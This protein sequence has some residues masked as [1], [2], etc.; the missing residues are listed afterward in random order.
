MYKWNAKETHKSS[1]EQQKCAQELIS[2]LAL[3]GNERE[4]VPQLI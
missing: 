4:A 1:A 2:K 3:N